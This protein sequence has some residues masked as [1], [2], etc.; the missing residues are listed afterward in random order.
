MIRRRFIFGSLLCASIALVRAQQS[1]EPSPSARKVQFTAT[2]EKVQIAARQGMPSLLLKTASGPVKLYLG[3]M[4][5]LIEEDFRPV[6]GEN[7]EVE[8]LQTGA[9][10]IAIRVSLTARKVTLRFRDSNG[11]PLWRHHGM[12][13]SEHHSR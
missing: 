5:Y 12:H 1:G 8:A 4:R 2:I 11:V 9:E 7:V 3:P 13:H 10:A 6:A